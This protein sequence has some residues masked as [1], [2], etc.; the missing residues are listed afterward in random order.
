MTNSL[1]R[2]LSEFEVILWE[3]TIDFAV[4][5]GERRNQL[6]S[7]DHAMRRRFSGP[8]IKMLT[9][10]YPEEGPI[11]LA[12]EMGRSQDSVSSFAHRCGLRTRPK[13]GVQE[14]N[15]SASEQTSLRANGSSHLFT[16]PLLTSR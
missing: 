2:F 8:E 9:D 16:D 14:P 10:R 3:Q 11:R 15:S 13:L 6:T 12:L 1:G 5:L 4:C 7:R